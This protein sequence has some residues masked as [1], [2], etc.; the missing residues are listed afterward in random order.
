MDSAYS[1][2]ELRPAQTAKH[3]GGRP[4]SSVGSSFKRYIGGRR[5][6]AAH[7]HSGCVRSA[8]DVSLCIN[9]AAQCCGQLRDRG[10][11]SRGPGLPRQV[12][13]CCRN[14]HECSFNF[15]SCQR[16]AFPAASWLE[17]RFGDLASTCL[18][19]NPEEQIVKSQGCVSN[20]RRSQHASSIGSSERSTRSESQSDADPDHLAVSRYEGFVEGVLTRKSLI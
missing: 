11:V 19:R 12:F 20:C 7:Q 15:I 13:S 3:S 17:T 16:V 10:W 14:E 6:A 1:M 4:A 2:R 18:S 9:E 8:A 5:S